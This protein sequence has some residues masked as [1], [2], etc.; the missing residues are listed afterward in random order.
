MW[1]QTHPLANT[2]T[3]Q[4]K[5]NL[6]RFFFQTSFYSL[7]GTEYLSVRN[8]AAVRCFYRPSVQGQ[9]RDEQLLSDTLKKEDAGQETTTSAFSVKLQLLSYCFK[10]EHILKP[11]PVTGGC[12]TIFPGLGYCVGTDGLVLSSLFLLLHPST[13]EQSPIPAWRCSTLLPV[14]RDF[15]PPLLHVSTSSIDEDAK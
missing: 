8:R 4:V 5:A 6:I 15:P 13:T 1:G 10:A 3:L 14:K 9:E 11:G 7:P 12:W 2:H